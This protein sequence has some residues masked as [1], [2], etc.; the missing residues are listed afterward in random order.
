MVD[1]AKRYRAV[2]AFNADCE[3][4]HGQVESPLSCVEPNQLTQEVGY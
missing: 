3:K 4:F 1:K 2:R